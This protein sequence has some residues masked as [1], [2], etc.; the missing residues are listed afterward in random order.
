MSG[1][2][3]TNHFISRY[4]E[5]IL[6]ESPPN[7]IAASLKNKI[8]EDMGTKIIQREKDFISRFRNCSGVVKLPFNKTHQ[9]VMKNKSLITVY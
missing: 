4:A 6:C 1:L 2:Y 3:I 5:R 8:M 7:K 9:I